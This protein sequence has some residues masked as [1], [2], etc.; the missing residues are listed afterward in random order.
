VVPGVLAQT[1]PGPIGR[2]AG[3]EDNDGNLDPEPATG[4]NFDWNSF[5]SGVTWTGT[6]PYR[7][8][9]GDVSGWHFTGLEDA[10]LPDWQGQDTIFGPRPGIGQPDLNTDCP[11]MTLGGAGT[12]Y[13]LK[14][15][16]LANKAVNGHLF[17]MLAWVRVAGSSSST[18]TANVA[19]E[20]NQGQKGPCAYQPQYSFPPYGLTQR[21]TG[22]FLILFDLAGGGAVQISASRWQESAPGAGSWSTPTT[23]VA[24]QSEGA[25]NLGAAPVQ[26]NLVPPLPG[27][28]VGT[29][30]QLPQR[31]FGEAGIDLTTAATQTTGCNT[32]SQ[33]K[34]MT[35]QGSAF[36]SALAD[37]AG[38]G[39]LALNPCGTLIVKKVT[40]DPRPNPTSDM[41]P[42]TVTGPQQPSGATPLPQQFGLTNG[43]MSPSLTVLPATTYSVAEA[44]PPNWELTSATCVNQNGAPSGGTLS[45][46]ALTNI[47][48]SPDDTVTCTFT[49][50]FLEGAI[51]L[52]KVDAVTGASLAGAT[53]TITGPG[54]PADGVPV[55]TADDGTAC[56]DRLLFDLPG[57]TYT[58]QETQAPPGYIPVPPGGGQTVHVE[59]NSV[60]DCTPST[61]NPPNAPLEP[62]RDPPIPLGAIEVTKISSD[63]TAALLEGARF[64]VTGPLTGPYATEPPG[65]VTQATNSLGIACFD[66]LPFGDYEVEETAPPPGS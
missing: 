29:T 39:N 30:E 58:V 41:F 24:N 12:N 54:L 6:A 31:T 7:A 62:F 52:E 26:D 33:V 46:N 10:F 28:T 43:G 45:G 23:L 40:Q 57:T 11:G 56:L 60:A 65:V 22:D 42:F 36:G 50:T 3:F 32:F 59:V 27:T 38:P 20:F 48:V 4:I 61:P 18:A 13:D 14:R 34:A 44:P 63:P 16:Y 8:G 15:V 47:A 9:T 1:V 35:R 55:T 49:D 19:L 21:T 2:A 53:F 64:S 66:G 17:L 25:V 51:T 37:F 5:A